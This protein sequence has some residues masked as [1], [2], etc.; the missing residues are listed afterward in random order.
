MEAIGELIRESIR[1]RKAMVESAIEEGQETITLP[2]LIL[3][4]DI[5]ELCLDILVCHEITI[6]LVHGGI[7]F[8]V[9]HYVGETEQFAD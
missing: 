2:E 3:Y 4:C 9:D 1:K 5:A 6:R 7:L 8:D